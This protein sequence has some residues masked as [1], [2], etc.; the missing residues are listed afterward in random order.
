VKPRLTHTIRKNK[1]VQDPFAS[2][3][4]HDNSCSHPYYTDTFPTHLQ[5]TQQ[6]NWPS[7]SPFRHT[8]SHPYPLSFSDRLRSPYLESSNRRIGQLNDNTYSPSPS[9]HPH[10]QTVYPPQIQHV[11]S[12]PRQH[13][14]F[15]LQ[16][17]SSSGYRYYESKA[18][19]RSEYL[20]AADRYRH[21]NFSSNESLHSPPIA[22][23]ARQGFKTSYPDPPLVPP[24]GLRYS[25]SFHSDRPPPQF[26]QDDPETHR[27]QDSLYAAEETLLPPAWVTTK[28]VRSQLELSGVKYGPGG[29]E[30]LQRGGD[31]IAR[32]SEN[33]QSD[34]GGNGRKVGRRRPRA[35]THKHTDHFNHPVEVAAA[36]SHFEETSTAAPPPPPLV[37]SFI[38]GHAN[39]VAT[40]T[41]SPASKQSRLHSAKKIKKRRGRPLKEYPALPE[42]PAN[43]MAEDPELR[44]MRRKLNNR[45]ACR[46]LRQRRKDEVVELE[47]DVQRVKDENDELKKTL[48]DDQAEKARWM[49]AEADYQRRQVFDFSPLLGFCDCVCGC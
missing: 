29:T 8:Q 38:D 27:R 25:T 12:P 41:S 16:S 37:K 43:P 44:D 4:Y 49:G 42:A 28:D 15:A 48:V 30:G 36:D 24:L 22:L 45:V 3:I 46:R 9:S 31:D 39:H 10:A 47:N 26:Q 5:P 13:D 18:S 14:G 20:P 32:G 21:L 34:C 11:N 2:D 40:A 35:R 1:D 23:S 7:T 33:L 19:P 6:V 17:S